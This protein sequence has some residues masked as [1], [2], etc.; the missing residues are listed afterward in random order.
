MSVREFLLPAGLNNFFIFADMENRF[1]TGLRP[2]YQLLLLALV[3]LVS[4]FVFT[5]IGLVGANVF[6]GVPLNEVLG[7]MNPSDPN[8]INMLKWMQICQSFGIFIV[9]A[10]VLG[11][12][13]DPKLF[14]YL[15]FRKN[16]DWTAWGLMLLLLLGMEPIVAFTG[17]LNQDLQLPAF[18]AGIEDW[19]QDME[20]RAMELTDAFLE[21]K[22]F[23]GLSVNLLMVAILPALGEELFFRGL[24]QRMLSRWFKN[25]HL[26]ILIT[27]LLFSALHMQFFGFLPRFLLGMLFGY[28]YVWS[29]N[30]WFPVLAHLIHNTIPVVA[31]YLYAADLTA[32]PVE[33]IGS[34]SHAW[35]WAVGGFI[36]LIIFTKSF[37]ERFSSPEII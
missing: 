32:T 10:L 5:L 13:A 20:T 12:M 31:Y 7:S 36:L 17:I 37:R 23:T 26:A 15:G 14:K 22:T 8:N 27:S 3:A 30:L 34:G 25:V 11:R 24:I 16:N 35:I 29:G 18:L 19:M 9:P 2:Y 6:F 21:V 4:F 1:F 33:E 28:L